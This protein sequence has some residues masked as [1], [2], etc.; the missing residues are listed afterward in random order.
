MLRIEFL[1]PIHQLLPSTSYSWSVEKE[2]EAHVGWRYELA[3]APIAECR[4]PIYRDHLSFSKRIS[5]IVILNPVRFPPGNPAEL[6]SE[7]L[8][9]FRY[10]W[11]FSDA[12]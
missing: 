10:S 5:R 3:R 9:G 4:T 8:S 6:C 2:I 7:D 1:L 11:Y 12:S